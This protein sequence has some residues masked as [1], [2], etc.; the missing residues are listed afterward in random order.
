MTHDLISQTGKVVLS[1]PLDAS[2]SAGSQYKCFIYLRGLQYTNTQK[3]Y[4]L[5]QTC[6]E[7]NGKYQIEFDVLEEVQNSKLHISLIGVNTL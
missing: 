6:S 1:T 7:V 4:G 2:Y 3:N 5:N